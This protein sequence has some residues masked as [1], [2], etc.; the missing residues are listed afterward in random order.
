MSSSFPFA[1]LVEDVDGYLVAAAVLAGTPINVAVRDQLTSGHLSRFR[2]FVDL[3]HGGRADHVVSTARNLLG[4]AGDTELAALRTA[5]IK[6]TG[7]WDTLLPGHMPDS[8]LDPFLQGYA[9]TLLGLVGQE[10][11]RRL[12][13]G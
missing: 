1:D 12:R 9:D 5:A 13:L 4:S 10:N 3:R 7:G 11:A 6:R 2:R 8:K